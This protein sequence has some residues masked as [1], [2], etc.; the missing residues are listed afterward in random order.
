MPMLQKIIVLSKKNLAKVFIG[1][2]AA[3]LVKVFT[4]LILSKVIAEKLGPGG[5]GQIG[6]LTSFVS[7]SLLFATGGYQNGIVTFTA[8]NKHMDGD[9][10]F[11]RA[12]LKLTLIIACI[13]SLILILM[14]QIFSQLI[15]KSPLYKYPFYF[16]GATLTLYSLNSYFI[17]YLNGLSDFKTLTYLNIINS[18][19]TLLISIA[20][21]YWMQT[22]GALIAVVIGQTLTSLATFHFIYKARNVFRGFHK[23]IISKKLLFQ[24]LPF[25]KMTVFS[26]LLMPLSHIIIRNTLLK[27]IGELEMGIWEAI[28]RISNLYLLIIFNVML[29]YYLPKLSTTFKKEA[30]YHEFKKGFILFGTVVVLL[31]VSIYLFRN[32]IISLFLS[33]AFLPASE[34]FS[35]QLTGDFFR[36]LSY[37]FSYFAIAKSLTNYYIIT[38]LLFFFIYIAAAHYMIPIFNAKGAVIAYLIM[39]A[40]ALLLHSF[41]ILKLYFQKRNNITNFI[42]KGNVNSPVDIT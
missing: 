36:V 28:N 26:V 8:I 42:F 29:M 24:L 12:T 13:A 17:A 41:F 14:A 25:V 6:Q 5:L 3:S 21:I 1:S 22:K 40:F 39:N 18:I 33:P 20:L 34:L 23:T 37:L 31:G 15:F 30:I 2:S 32:I 7:I 35:V 9:G 4:S 38:E 16:M 19:F 11:A 10:S 27:T